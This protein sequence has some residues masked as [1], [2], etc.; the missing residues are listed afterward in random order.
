MTGVAQNGAQTPG[1]A[2][3]ATIAGTVLDSNGDV[4][5]GAQ[6]VLS[7]T[8][9]TYRVLTSGEDGQ[10]T[11]TGLPPNAY[12]LTVSREGM[13]PTSRRSWRFTPARCG[14]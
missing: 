2:D 8:G 11:F 1:A 12:H 13:G 5:E 9:Q 3:P 7:A 6:V 4:I 10:F 14:L